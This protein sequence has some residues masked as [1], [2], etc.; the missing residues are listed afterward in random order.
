MKAIF[1]SLFY[2]I[3]VFGVISLGFILS[4]SHPI[5]FV[6][7]VAILLFAQIYEEVKEQDD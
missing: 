3:L 7:F 4:Y 6:I 2:T 1:K 5:I